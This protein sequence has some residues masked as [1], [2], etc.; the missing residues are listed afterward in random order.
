MKM[1]ELYINKTVG[2]LHHF[3]EVE[4]TRRAAPAVDFRHAEC[5][6]ML[7]WAL[8]VMKDNKDYETRLRIFDGAHRVVKGGDIT[9]WVTLEQLE[10]W[11]PPYTSP[12]TSA[13]VA[14]VAAA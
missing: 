2:A 3:I 12:E 4:G 10:K 6:T 1:L 5:D 9:R 11:V 7:S 8:K 14:G 13:A